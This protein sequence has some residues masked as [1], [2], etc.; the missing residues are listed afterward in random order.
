MEI[1][2]SIFSEQL[3]EAGSIVIQ[4]DPLGHIRGTGLAI[5]KQITNNWL[6]MHLTMVGLMSPRGSQFVDGFPFPVILAELQ[7]P[8]DCDF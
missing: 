5:L 6:L 8:Q 3:W 4:A 1:F 2:L 7:F